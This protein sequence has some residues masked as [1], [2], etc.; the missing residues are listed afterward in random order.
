MG[1]NPN[2]RSSVYQNAEG[3]HGRVTVGTKDNGEPD[4]RH[5]RGK[6]KTEVTIKVRKLEELRDEGRVPK[7]GQRWHVSEW[8]THWVETIATPPNISENTPGW[9]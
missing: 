2:G 4:R 3:W 9:P 1:R 8:L 5:V 7:A 6:T